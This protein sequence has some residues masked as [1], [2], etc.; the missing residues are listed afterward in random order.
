MLTSGSG[1][2]NLLTGSARQPLLRTLGER[3]DRAQGADESRSGIASRQ[4]RDEVRFRKSHDQGPSIRRDAPFIGIASFDLVC[5]LV[6][7]SFVVVWSVKS[8]DAYS[9]TV[10][11]RGVPPGR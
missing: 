4:L 9:G 10:D 2:Q 1:R 5:R 7:N 8:V 3:P 11:G 6:V